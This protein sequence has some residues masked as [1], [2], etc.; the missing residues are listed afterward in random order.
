MTQRPR[1]TGAP[2]HGRNRVRLLA[3][4]IGYPGRAQMREDATPEGFDSPLA[5]HTHHAPHGAPRKGI[6]MAS[7]NTVDVTLDRETLDALIRACEVRQGRLYECM[8]KHSNKEGTKL[9]T[10]EHDANRDAL[11]KLIAA[12][13]KLG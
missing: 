9:W 1:P 7:N 12:S 8:P 5:T 3:V 13:R 4:R 2:A 6:T 10:R 11:A